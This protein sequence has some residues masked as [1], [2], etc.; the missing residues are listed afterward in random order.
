[1]IEIPA[2]DLG[3]SWISVAL[4]SCWV[5][6]AKTVLYSVLTV[7]R[8]CRSATTVTKEGNI[9]NSFPSVTKSISDFGILGWQNLWELVRL[10][11]IGPSIYDHII[12][13]SITWNIRRVNGKDH[14]YMCFCETNRNEK[15]VIYLKVAWWN[16]WIHAWQIMI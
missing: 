13:Q 11:S 4:E 1:M 15:D 9:F 2:Q 3:Q 14:E 7:S 12:C 6:C 5:S 8:E 10:I 16:W